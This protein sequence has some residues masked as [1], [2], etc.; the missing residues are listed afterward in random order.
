MFYG[1]VELTRH[2]SQTRLVISLE[3]SL[4]FDFHMHICMFL[5]VEILL[6]MSK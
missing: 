1:N 3:V 2:V 5:K 6:R 4:E